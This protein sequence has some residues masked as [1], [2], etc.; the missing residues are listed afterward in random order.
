MNKIEFISVLS[1]KL[2]KLPHDERK[3]ALRYYEEYFEEAQINDETNVLDEL[4]NPSEIA[5]QILSEYAVKELNNKTVKKKISSIWFILLALIVSPFAFPIALP[6][7]IFLFVAIIL[8]FVFGFVFV[9]VSTSLVG[10]GISVFASGISSI[11]SNVGIGLMSI[12]TGIIM[13]G[14]TVLTFIGIIYVISKLFD[15]IVT[16]TNKRLKSKEGEKESIQK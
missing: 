1:K 16:S 5:A 12:G 15:F 9:V 10:A 6:I 8:I 2:E 13:V 3:D 14:I 4:P 7:L 11:F